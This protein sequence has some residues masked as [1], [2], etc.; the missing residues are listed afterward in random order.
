MKQMI[1]IL[2]SVICFSPLFAQSGKIVDTG[3]KAA[4]SSKEF[5]LK[6]GQ[7]AG[8][9]LAR[10]A[11]CN[12]PMAQI[13]NWSGQPLVRV[14]PLE[15]IVVPFSPENP[16][17]LLAKVLDYN[18]AAR[19]IFPEGRDEHKI[20]IPTPWENQTQ[21]AWYRGMKIHNLLELRNL[22]EN[23]L[24]LSKISPRYP[25]IFSTSEI[26]LALKHAVPWGA[27]APVLPVVVKMPATFEL[28]KENEP[29][30]YADFLRLFRR[31]IRPDQIED[32]MVFLSVN[33]TPGWYK[34][35]LQEGELVFIPAFG[36]IKTW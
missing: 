17:S 29:D 4:S 13:L 1:L 7:K 34:V 31:D 3:M 24:E 12:I 23:G 21:P 22:L 8:Q 5:V 30:G 16:V 25:G 32:V 15:D 10:Q 36:S 6:V 18:V 2:L 27:V 11:V 20:Y 9:Q 14:R 35:V 26:D 28:S 19:Y 33:E